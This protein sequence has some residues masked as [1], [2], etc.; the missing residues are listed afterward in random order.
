MSEH[1]PLSEVVRPRLQALLDD[2]GSHQGADLHRRVL[3][4]VERVLI[5]EVLKRS[6]GN[7]KAAAAILGIHRNTLRDRRGFSSGA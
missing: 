7:R 1:E 2:L 3:A 5:E 4:E 6:A